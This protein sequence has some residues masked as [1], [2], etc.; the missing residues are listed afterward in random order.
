MVRHGTVDTEIYLHMRKLQ[1]RRETLDFSP[2]SYH[3]RRSLKSLLE[4]K[5]IRDVLDK[6]LEVSAFWEGMRL[7]TFHKIVSMKCDEVSKLS[8]Q[9]VL[10]L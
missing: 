2:L 1:L 10:I 5:P 7:S 3:G 6:V 8:K 9:M 4:N